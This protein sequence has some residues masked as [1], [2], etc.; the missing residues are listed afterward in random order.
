MKIK[1]YLAYVHKFIIKSQYL[2]VMYD[3]I[4]NYVYKEH[5]FIHFISKF[6]FFVFKK[7]IAN[8]KKIVYCQHMLLLPTK[9]LIEGVIGVK[10]DKRRFMCKHIHFSWI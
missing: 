9:K 4:Y 2:V 7:L 6:L 5:L 8:Y 10:R 1:N 3:K